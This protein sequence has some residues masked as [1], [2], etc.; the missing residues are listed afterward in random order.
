MGD[1]GDEQR[2]EVIT[3]LCP[4]LFAVSSFV[5]AWAAYVCSCP[6]PAPSAL[7]AGVAFPSRLHVCSSPLSTYARRRRLRCCLLCSFGPLA[8]HCCVSYRIVVIVCLC[9]AGGAGISISILGSSSSSIVLLVSTMLFCD[10]SVPLLLDV[11]CHSLVWLSLH[12]LLGVP[13]LCLLCDHFR[14]FFVV[15]CC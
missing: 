2:S 4:W 11:G 15:R 5:P 10:V 14:F 8:L 7:F 3:A 6:P 1:D 9:V 13:C 12:I